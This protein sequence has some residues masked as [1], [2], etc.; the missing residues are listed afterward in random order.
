MTTNT[1]ETL[2]FMES[3][4]G[5]PLT[6]GRLLLSLRKCD[7]V[8]QTE[9]AKKAKI[10]KGLICDIEKGRRDASIELVIKL[11]KIMGYS[12]ESFLSILFE[13]QLRR[14]KSKLKVRIE[15]AA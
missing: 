11:A 12:P 5:G 6:F 3:I 9:L 15:E 14:A 2:K 13:E 1:K 4:T 8:S 10:S 7:E